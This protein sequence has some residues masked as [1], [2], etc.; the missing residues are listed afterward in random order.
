MSAPVLTETDILIEN[1]TMRD[2][3]Y[4]AKVDVPVEI[5][6]LS[7]SEVLVGLISHE[8]ARIQMA[9]IPLF[10]RHPHFIDF[11]PDVVEKLSEAEGTVLKL[12]YTAAVLLQDIHRDKLQR[13]LGDTSLLKDIYSEELG[14]EGA[15]TEERLHLLAASHVHLSGLD[16]NWVGTYRHSANQFLKSLERWHHRHHKSE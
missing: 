16:I 9:L 4:F 2:V 5:P 14:V 7:D 13:F 6:Y 11:V 12:Y 1:L 3:P 15:S 8:G 10:L